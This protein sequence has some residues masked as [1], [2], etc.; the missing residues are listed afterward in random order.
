MMGSTLED[1]DAIN[2]NNGRCS[3]RRQT[4]REG[5]ATLKFS[6]KLFRAMMQDV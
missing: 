1:G 4:V 6:F 3:R 2:C 5:R